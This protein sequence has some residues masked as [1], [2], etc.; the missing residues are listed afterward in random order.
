MGGNDSDMATNEQ[1][2]ENL[3]RQPSWSIFHSWRPRYTNENGGV[4]CHYKPMDTRTR[5]L[6][7]SREMAA[8]LKSN[9]QASKTRCKKHQACTII[10]NEH[11]W[12]NV[13]MG[14]HTGVRKAEPPEAEDD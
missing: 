4:S 11:Y 2:L 6:I 9:E 8:W 13:Q 10:E 12:I 5:P 3:H 14:H 1:Y 7:V